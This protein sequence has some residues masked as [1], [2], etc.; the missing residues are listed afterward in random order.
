MRIR[1]KTTFYQSSG[2]EG[3]SRSPPRWLSVVGEEGRGG[4]NR[5]PPPLTTSLSTEAWQAVSWTTLHSCVSSLS[6]FLSV[7]NANESPLV[8]QTA[9]ENEQTWRKKQGSDISL[10]KVKQHQPN[11]MLFMFSLLRFLTLQILAWVKKWPSDRITNK[12]KKSPNYCGI[13]DTVD[14]WGECWFSEVAFG[15]VQ[16]SPK[17]SQDQT[18][19]YLL[20]LLGCKPWS[21]MGG[22]LGGCPSRKDKRGGSIGGLSLPLLLFT[23]AL[24]KEARGHGRLRHPAGRST[25]WRWPFCFT[26]SHCLHYLLY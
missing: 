14:C 6:V 11:A 12:T 18:E 20:L 4:W 26:S 7:S 25:M 24:L 21:E 2:P 8:R 22:N 9:S 15:C 16:T 19:G 1:A 5:L 17:P 3:G 13:K 10:L 23:A